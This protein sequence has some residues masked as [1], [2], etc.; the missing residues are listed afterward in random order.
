[1]NRP[2]F[3]GSEL[4]E[5]RGERCKR[6]FKPRRDPDAPEGL[7]SLACLEAASEEIS[8]SRLRALTLARDNGV[9]VDCGLDCLALRREIDDMQD[10]AS[11]NRETRSTLEARIH[12]LHRLGFDKH[13]VESGQALW[14]MDHELEVARGGPNALS[15]TKTRC[16]PCHKAKSKQFAKKRSQ[17][18]KTRDRRGFGRG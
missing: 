16:L 13:A 3:K 5:P 1:M 9:C 12:Q 7:C 4:Q 11:I 10:W 8:D 6:C 14:E 17:S 15:N 18:R 2:V